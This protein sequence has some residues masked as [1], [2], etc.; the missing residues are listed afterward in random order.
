MQEQLNIIVDYLRGI[1]LK[2]RYILIFSWIIC[3]IGWIGVTFL[4]N[5][6]TSEAKVYADTQS[7]LRPLL[8]GLAIQTDPSQRLDL[9]A[10]TLLNRR[11]LDIIGKD[12]DANIVARTPEEYENILDQL[13]DDIEIHTTG[14]HNLYTISY[15]GDT[16]VYARNVVQAVLNVFI[17]STLGDK[18][19]DTE[20]AS[21][22]IK[23]Q[24]SYY[25]KRLIDAEKELADFKREY[26]GFLPGSD[27]T[28]YSNLEEEKLALESAELALKEARSQLNEA[29]YQLGRERKNSLQ[30]ISNIQTEYD[31][32][33]DAVESRLDDLLFRY[34]DKHPD[35]VETKRQLEELKDLKTTA[36]RR[37]SVNDA[38][39]DNL[40]YQN[41]KMTINNITNEIASLEVRVEKHNKKI[42]DLQSKLDVVPD[43]EAMLTSLTRNYN[44]TKSKYEE[45]LSRGESASISYSVGESSEEIKFKIIEPPTIPLAPSGPHRVLFILGVLVVGIGSG[46]GVSFVISQIVPVASST[47]QLYRVTGIPVFGVVSATDGSGLL[48]REKRRL[49]TFI[50]M[51]LLLMVALFIS[52]TV[53]A[54]PAIYTNLSALYSELKLEYMNWL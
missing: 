42:S 49:I 44:I 20:E 34:T 51:L 21:D 5:Q 43:V 10:R 16:P 8:R 24:I 32:R 23:N 54:V 48:V 37:I 41:L 30:Q 14:G 1:W 12:V 4:P 9:M 36:M 2:R 53:N 18:R 29:K 27:R 31:V 39:R 11:N 26:I 33:I 3:P 13:R 28:Y 50:L 40:V 22:V 7:I 17:E 6:Y 35:V 19:L 25:E 46:V 15:T 52:I 47:N 38:L 45:L